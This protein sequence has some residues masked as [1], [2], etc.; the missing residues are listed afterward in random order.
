MADEYLLDTEPVDAFIEHVRATIEGSA[1][2]ATS[3]SRPATTYTASEPPRPRP[4]SRSTS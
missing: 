3:S 1:S 4:P 2:P